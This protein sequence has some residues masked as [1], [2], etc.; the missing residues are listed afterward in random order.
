[1]DNL[2]LNLAKLRKVSANKE[3]KSLDCAVLFY[4]LDHAR[5]FF[6]IPSKITFNFFITNTF[7]TVLYEL[8][9]QAQLNFIEF[10]D[11]NTKYLNAFLP[12][13]GVHKKSFSF[14]LF[15]P[16]GL[17]KYKIIEYEN[18]N[19]NIVSKNML[20]DDYVLLGA[21]YPKN[22]NLNSIFSLH[23]IIVFLIFFS[24]LVI[25]C[26]LFVSYFNYINNLLLL[27]ISL[28]IFLFFLVFIY[29]FIVTKLPLFVL[30]CMH[31][32]YEKSLIRQEQKKIEDFYGIIFNFI[33]LL[34]FCLVLL[35]SVI[36]IAI[37]LKN[38]M[39]IIFSLVSL[40]F[41]I[42]YFYFNIQ[43]QKLQS[44]IESSKINIIDK[45]NEYFEIF[46][47]ILSFKKQEFFFQKIIT[48]F[49]GLLLNII[50]Y[51]KYFNMKILFIMASSFAWFFVLNLF[52][53]VFK[54][55][56]LDWQVWFLSVLSVIFLF[57]MERTN[58]YIYLMLKFYKDYLHFSTQDF[59]KKIKVRPVHIEGSIELINICFSFDEQ[60]SLL[61]KDLSLSIKPGEMVAIVAKSGA[62]KSS[63]LSIL[64]GITRPTKGLVVF[65]GQDAQSLDLLML[66][67]YF[68]LITHATKL[69]AGSVFDN[70]NFGRNISFSKVNKLINSHEIFSS[71]LQ[72]PMGLNTYV[73]WHAK[74][75]SR[76]DSYLIFLARALI[77]QPKVLLLDEAL[78]GLS[79]QQQISLLTY[80]KNLN[81]TCVIS[82]NDLVP[83]NYFDQIF[84]IYEFSLN[85]IHLA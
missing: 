83:Q 15:I 33:W 8:C 31:K 59:S 38:F 29:I 60:S 53:I 76:F 24:L 39:F 57:F 7:I 77:E 40:L 75:I 61:F 23:K 1:M 69:F 81:L 5:N 55:T 30:I 84:E 66:S 63:L 79:I 22:I 44:K 19:K 2:I 42:I 43:L 58:N 28:F 32:F 73:F 20:K 51:I 21:F 48:Y 49:D 41:L 35:F 3:E 27:L 54:L 36:S 46:S 4:L 72:L 64:A 80:L 45:T 37:F 67:D 85:K 11:F 18:K 70:I 71:L 10:N 78:A 13:I 14:S 62:G 34:F 52:I 56:I 50:K 12:L 74:N 9:K 65:D 16:Y 82:S 68:A 25:A 6:N 26:F 47:F 17:S